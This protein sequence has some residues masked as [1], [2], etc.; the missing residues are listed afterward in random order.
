MMVC[1]RSMPPYLR[2]LWDHFQQ[3]EVKNIQVAT[4]QMWVMCRVYSKFT[5]NVQKNKNTKAYHKVD[6]SLKKIRLVSFLQHVQQ[7]PACSFATSWFSYVWVSSEWR[8]LVGGEFDQFWQ[9]WWFWMTLECLFMENL[10]QFGWTWWTI[11][12]GGSES[13]SRTRI[14]ASHC[15]QCKKIKNSRFR[16]ILNFFLLET[17][18]GQHHK[19]KCSLCF[20]PLI[21]VQ[22]FRFFWFLIFCNW[23]F[24]ARIRFLQFLVL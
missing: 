10:D 15:H 17:V 13:Q 21:P 5:K 23:R 14:L 9:T 3:G 6:L 2:L 1:M 24:R 18:A 4:G 20:L 19:A 11:L 12:S 16:K 22:R 7:S 8:L